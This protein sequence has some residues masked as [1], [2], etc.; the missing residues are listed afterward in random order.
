V[1]FLL[2][3]EKYKMTWCVPQLIIAILMQVFQQFKLTGIN[4]NAKGES[5]IYADYWIP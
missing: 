3:N 2:V 1:L 5:S 4:A